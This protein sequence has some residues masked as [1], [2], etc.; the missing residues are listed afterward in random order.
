MVLEAEPQAHTSA[1]LHCGR[2]SRG[3]SKATEKVNKLKNMGLPGVLRTIDLSGW[4]PGTLHG[5]LFS[6][7]SEGSDARKGQGVR[8]EAELLGDD[9]GSEAGVHTAHPAL[10]DGRLSRLAAS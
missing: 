8:P 7:K 4:E 3:R 5:G 6:F 10:L 1:Y 2:S 9:R